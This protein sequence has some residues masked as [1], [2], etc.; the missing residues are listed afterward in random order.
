MAHIK[1]NHH[2]NILIHE[3]NKTYIKDGFTKQPI[4]VHNDKSSCTLPESDLSFDSMIEAYFHI[5]ELND[6]TE[7]P[8]ISSN[9]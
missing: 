4:I 9:K 1:P 6:D 7:P 8:R 2:G 3:N 5:N